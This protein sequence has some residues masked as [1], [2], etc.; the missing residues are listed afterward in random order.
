MT[1]K[2]IKEFY[3]KKVTEKKPSAGNIGSSRLSIRKISTKQDADA[4]VVVEIPLENLANAPVRYNQ[5][6]EIEMSPV[7]EQ[8]PNS[9]DQMN[10]SVMLSDV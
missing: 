9:G 10:V 8:Q 3:K 2:S 1:K 6:R 7:L 5:S 4:S